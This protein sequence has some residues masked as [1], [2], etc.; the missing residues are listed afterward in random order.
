MFSLV[1][2]FAVSQQYL[3]NDHN[4][5]SFFVVTYVFFML[6]ALELCVECL[7]ATFTLLCFIVGSDCTISVFFHPLTRIVCAHA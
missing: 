5:S 3:R 6:C 1:H 7:A 4:A 2:D